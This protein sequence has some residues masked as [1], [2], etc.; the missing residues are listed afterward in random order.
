MSHRRNVWVLAA[1][2]G[3][4]VAQAAI[5]PADL[6]LER[7]P[8]ATTVF[9]KPIGVRH[10]N[11]GSGR[12]FVLEKCGKIK[13]VSNGS[14]L[15][16]PFATISVNCNGNEQGLLGLAFDPGYASNG[17]FY[18]SYTAPSTGQHTLERYTVS[19]NPDVANPSGTLIMSVPDIASNHNGG[20]V[21]F[22]ADGYLYWS[23]GDGGVQGDPN[24]FAQCTGRKK[25]DG[26]PASCYDLSGSGVTYYLLG[27]I[28]RLD[29]HAT[30][31]SAQNLCGVASGASAPYAIPPSNPFA[32]AGAHPNDCAEVFNW[33]YRNPFRF[34][35]DRQ[36]GDMLIG[37]VGQDRYEE[38]DF[39]PAGSA[40][41]N[42]QWNACEGFHTYP[43][44]AANCAGP[45]G[46]VPPKI[47]LSH[48]GDGVCAVIGGY[49]YRGPIGP[50]RGQYLFSDNCSRKIYVV[51]NPAAA[52]SPW[53]FEI[54][55][56]APGISAYSF[57][58]DGAGNVFVT[59]GAGPIF[60]F[61]SDIIF[62]NGF[63][64]AA[65]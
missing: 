10:A 4:G 21:Q 28:L 1:A 61:A 49:V 37:D 45:A 29:V 56:G 46:S 12:A 3:A 15:A 6:H 11:D 59:D 60:R 36:T 16:T 43:G 22:G 51:A 2:L 57:G 53:S 39:Q 13:I 20:D 40:G 63:D 9:S 32:N 58:E 5:S 54:L 44:N 41:Q 48:S 18:V 38:I 65:H 31:A 8:N 33:G 23:I 55:P 47:E 17:E 27:K 35:F 25:A 24:G 14:V 50:L 30:T 42:F 19:A 26:N 34:S 52:V 62:A 7:W 64:G